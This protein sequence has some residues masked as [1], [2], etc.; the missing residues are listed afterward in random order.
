MV[1]PL[2]PGY[3]MPVDHADAGSVR[4]IMECQ[5]MTIS[6]G[7]QSIFARLRRDGIDPNEYISFYGLRSWARMQDGTLATSDVSLINA[8]IAVILMT[9]RADLYSCQMYGGRRPCRYHRFC[10]HK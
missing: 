10:K 9:Q 5:F 3:P 8:T 4:L 2:E 7:E 6:R 1:I